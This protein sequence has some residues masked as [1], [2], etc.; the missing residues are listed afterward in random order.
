MFFAIASKRLGYE[1]VGWDPNPSA[2][3]RTWVDHFV[4][5]PFT[6]LEGGRSFLKETRAVTY[7]W[8]NI[9]IELVDTI[10]ASVPVRPQGRV[11]SLLQNRA[12]QKK[13]LKNG[14]FPV[15]PFLILQQAEALPPLAQTLGLPAICKTTTA[16]YDGH[17]QWQLEEA[18][19]VT[20]L[21]ES[22]RKKP[23]PTGWIL[24]KKISYEK[25]LSV[26][27]VRDE[28][29]M[30]L[31]YPVVD[32]VHEKGVLRT[33]EAP[34]DIDPRLAHESAL[35]ARE[36]IQALDGIGVFCVELFL[37]P[38]GKLLINEIAPRPHNSG[39]YTMDICPSSQFEQQV[40]LLCGLPPGE[41]RL[42]S[43]AV[44][45][46]ILGHEIEKTRS[47]EG[48]EKLLAIPGCRI[49]DYRKRDIKMGRKMGHITLVAEDLKIA[50]KRAGQVQ[51]FLKMPDRTESASFSL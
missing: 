8:E 48:S 38:D 33:S 46:N 14:G 13:F 10:E 37:S 50:R 23:H 19:Q 47:Q 40:R 21:S 22:L 9:P 3:I 7:E 11:L 43:P 42:L 34:A 35:L 39:H 27:V 31:T 6:D 41:P 15:A 1:V 4:S 24:E 12:S 20:L 2:P 29:G 49:Y 5:V 18:H 25:E 45:V 30:L 16:G 36:A 32:N 26:V 51:S 28:K 44:M 17:G